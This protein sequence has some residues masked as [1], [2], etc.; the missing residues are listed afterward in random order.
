MAQTPQDLWP[1]SHQVSRSLLC[2]PRVR[3]IVRKHMME[4]GVHLTI[5]EDVLSEVATITQM[6]MLKE[7]NAVE[8]VY[9]VIFRV[10]YLVTS[11][12]GKK[13]IN[14]NRSDELSLSSM[15]EAQDVTE[16][17]T[18]DRLNTTQTRVDAEEENERKI[19]I[20]NAKARFAKKLDAVG[21]PEEVE[22]ERTTRGRRRKE[23][24]ISRQ[25]EEA[26]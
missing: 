18:V 12:Y 22:K 10:S 21:W 26:A 4:R 5:M 1:Y 24:P 15:S 16:A 6:K 17:D 19:D 23:N 11:N 9:F 2:C 8:D 20:D 13:A 3:G 25:S 14:T 7:L